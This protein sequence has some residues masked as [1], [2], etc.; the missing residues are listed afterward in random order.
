MD[1]HLFGNWMFLVFRHSLSRA[2]KVF[3]CRRHVFKGP[4]FRSCTSNFFPTELFNKTAH[5]ILQCQTYEGGFGGV[6]GMEAH[7]GYCFCGLVNIIILSI[8]HFRYPDT[9]EFSITELVRLSRFDCILSILHTT[10]WY[11]YLLLTIQKS[12][13]NFLS[14]VCQ[15]FI[16]AAF[17]L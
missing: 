17:F 11:Y 1:I 8:L 7:G 15:K 14:K 2:S 3:N 16:D 5:W 4:L 6:P 13:N 12:S 9:I 10:H